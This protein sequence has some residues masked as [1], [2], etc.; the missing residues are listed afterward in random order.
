[1]LPV[2]T[3]FGCYHR[4]TA[5]PVPATTTPRAKG[6]ADDLPVS[7]SVLHDE[8]RQSGSSMSAFSHGTFASTSS[9]RKSHALVVRWDPG[10]GRDRNTQDR[11]VLRQWRRHISMSR[12]EHH[13][14][15]R[16]IRRGIGPE[17]RRQAR[18]DRRLALSAG[19]YS[20]ALPQSDGPSSDV[21]RPASQHRW[22]RQIFHNA[23]AFRGRK[24]RWRD[25]ESQIDSL[26]SSHCRNRACPTPRSRFVDL[27]L[28]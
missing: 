18:P 9:I 19:R 16:D 26:H 23:F 7:R 22:R 8:H 4:R 1:M 15:A 5:P 25:R 3:H 21:R 6:S 12:A 13:L 20:P 27:S 24:T 2:S 28:M 17:W 10:R 11:R 14:N